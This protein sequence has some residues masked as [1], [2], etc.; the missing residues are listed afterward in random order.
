MKPPV[1]L[2]ATLTR[3]DALFATAG[4]AGAWSAAAQTGAARATTIQGTVDTHQRS[5]PINPFIYG[6][7]LEHG[8]NIINHTMW[9]EMLHDRKFYY[10]MLAA[11]EP[12]PDPADFRASMAY[13]HKWT[14]VGP[15]AHIALDITDA[16]VGAHSPAIE[17]APTTP[18]GIVQSHVAVV[19]RK[20][21][22]G[23]IVLKATQDTEVAIHLDEGA[24]GAQTVKVRAGRDWSTVHFKFTAV[25]D[26]A[27]ARFSVTATGAGT[28]RIGAVSLM[29]AD[30]IKGF[31]ADTIAL[32]KE[33]DCKILRMPGGNFIS[34]YDW[35]DTIGDPDKRPPVFDPVWKALQPN[36]AGLD[37]LLQM[38]ELIQCEPYWCV[39]TGFG[40]PRSGAEIV[41]YVNGAAN[42]F[43]GA[44]RAANGRVQPYK[45]RYWNIGNEMYGHWQFGHM[46]RDQY[47]IKHNLFADAMRKV[48]PWI[49][50]VA[51]GGFVDEMTT[52]QGIFVAGQPQVQVGS[53]RDW[54]YGM[55]KF[56]K[57][58]FDALA[59]H[60]YPPENKRF[61]LKSGKLFDV[62]QSPVEWARQPAN[63]I[64]TMVDAWEDYKKLFPELADGRVKVFF[65]E[66]AY[67][68]RDSMKGTLPIAIAFHEFFKHTDFIDMAGYTMATAWMNVSPTAS[69]ISARGR[70]FQLYNQRFG[71]IPVAVGGNSPQPAP[72]YPA[73]GDQPR[74]NT[75][76]ATYPLDVMAALTADETVLTVAVVNPT[77]VAQSLEL[78]FNGFDAGSVGRCWTLVGKDLAATNVAGAPPDVVIQE[79][80]FDARARRIDIAPASVQILHFPRKM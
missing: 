58:R 28:L 56:C 35:K 1:N 5:K 7:F 22:T 59:T 43:W 36:D 75:G 47:V 40:E 66:W 18:R 4:L 20:A 46:S 74:V 76:S 15:V 79:T 42:T 61:D 55:L 53:E 29:P 9:A 73:G 72:Q 71:R 54:A 44:K 31:R 19:G 24:Q 38:C 21:Y 60:A 68:F 41:E 64:A 63:R 13:I 32:M 52:G 11:E 67:S 30:N 77:E 65:D 2:P 34:A 3:R 23:R 12:R 6:G 69:A 49:Y 37:E 14:A 16:Y 25:S 27:E 10:G 50:I 8:A 45:V 39:N 62:K 80:R 48:D 51:P 57:G 78:T 17:L 26:T 70:V 33:M